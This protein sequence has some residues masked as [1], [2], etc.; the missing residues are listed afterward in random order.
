[1][2][3]IITSLEPALQKLSEIFCVSMDTIR[4][5][6][7]EYILMYGQYECVNKTIQAV[8]YSFITL[9][10]IF[11]VV[12]M[13]IMSEGS[14][15]DDEDFKKVFKLAGIAIVVIELVIVMMMTIT[16]FICPEM[17]SINA[18]MKLIN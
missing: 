1:M 18:V 15:A 9:F 12:I 11:F 3:K 7:M 10:I 4:L 17:Y 14:I 8:G 16:Y 6:G 5:H 2:D 13:I